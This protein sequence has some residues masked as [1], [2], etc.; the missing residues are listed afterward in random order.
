M[1][2]VLFDYKIPCFYSTDCGFAPHGEM[3]YTGTSFDDEN[4][5]DGMLVFFDSKSF[6]LVYRITYPKLVGFLSLRLCIPIFI[7]V[8]SILHN[9]QSCIR[10]SWQ[11]KIN[12]ILVGLS[13]GSLRLYY[14]PVN[15]LRGALLCVSRPLRRARQQEVIREEL[16]LSR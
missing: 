15:S 13:D 11:P 6:N 7:I 4:E 14:D 2:Q 8:I 3:V 9:F 16:V 1:I 5:S 12:Q 10:I